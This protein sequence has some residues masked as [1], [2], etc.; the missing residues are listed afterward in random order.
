MS[1][2]LAKTTRSFTILM[3]HGTVHAVL[4]TP[5]GDQERSRLRAEW[6]MKDCRDMIEVR[7]IDG[8]DAS[9]QAMP[10]AERRVVIKTYLDHDENNTF[11]DASRIYRSF[12]DYVRSLTPE[13]RAAQFNPDLANNPPVG[14]LIHFAFIETMRE[15]GE[16]IPA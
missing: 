14:P 16:P 3:Q 8:Y 15:L 13:E 7:A 6:Y 9:V 2:S 10:L 1:I 5:A 4:L 12:R 11:R